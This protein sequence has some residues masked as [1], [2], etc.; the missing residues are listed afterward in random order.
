MNFSKLSMDLLMNIIESRQKILLQR[1]E[2][3]TAFHET[4]PIG[5]VVDNDGNSDKH[6]DDTEEG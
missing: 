5:D 3:R 1:L 6:E 2:Y 4:F